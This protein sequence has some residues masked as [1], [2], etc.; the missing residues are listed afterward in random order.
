MPETAYG[1]GEAT[2]LLE[3]AASCPF[4]TADRRGTANYLDGAARRRAAAASESG[5]VVSLARPLANGPT[6]RKDDRSAMSVELFK[7]DHGGVIMGSD[8]VEL[9]CHGGINT[10]LDAPNHIGIGGTW[11]GNRPIDDPD[12]PSIVDLASAGLVARA[13]FVDIPAVL[14]TPWVEADR[15]VNGEDIDRALATADVTFESGD[16]LLLYM[17]R[18]RYEAAGHTFPAP[19]GRNPGLGE[20][21]ARWVAKHQTSILCW[22]F[23]DAIRVPGHS[24]AHSLLWAIGQLLV[25]N[26]DFASLKASG[27]KSGVV[28]TLVVA[29]LA[30]PGGTGCVVNPLVLR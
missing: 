13:V 4:G 3:L 24:D 20:E 18:D 1:R 2:W 11:Y 14:G 19:G 27:A 22:D 6:A 9:D 5:E 12:P 30:V 23:L 21:G 15:P 25:D 8:H 16:A 28:G 10:H 17:G 29:P 26:C 7:T